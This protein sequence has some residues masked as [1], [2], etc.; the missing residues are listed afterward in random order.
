M[1]KKKKQH[2]T[3]EQEVQ[4]NTQQ[5]ISEETQQEET[6]AQ[7]TKAET[8]I[9]DTPEAETEAENSTGDKEVEIL[10]DELAKEKDKYIRLYSEFENFR[11]RTAKEKLELM[12]TAN[13]KAFSAL[14]PILDDFERANENAGK[15]DITVETLRE[16]SELIFNKFKSTLEKEGLSLIEVNQGDEFDTE[17]QE[18]ITQIPSPSPELK[19]KIVDVVEKDYKLGDKVIRFSKVVIGA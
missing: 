2:I 16:G 1:T 18:A 5:D 14:L 7:E 6:T 11:R 8:E 10:K 9:Q 15:E 13:E 4:A 19:G 17:F 12:K 3:E